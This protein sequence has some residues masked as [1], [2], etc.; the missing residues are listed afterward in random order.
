M[1]RL[2]AYN[3]G[4]FGRNFAKFLKMLLIETFV[5]DYF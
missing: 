4:I 1:F 2:R 3:F 5:N